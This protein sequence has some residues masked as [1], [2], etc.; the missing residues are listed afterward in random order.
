MKKWSFFRPFA[1]SHGKIDEEQPVENTL[2]QQLDFGWFNVFLLWFG[3]AAH[4]LDMY[5]FDVKLL[6]DL[7]IE[8]SYDFFAAT[9]CLVV[10]PAALMSL[11]S[12]RWYKTLLI[13]RDLPPDALAVEDT[14]WSKIIRIVCHILLIS[15][16]AR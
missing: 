6:Y 1:G 14:V 8:G 11:W 12:W 15:S 9:L 2:D 4:I 13:E 10:I 5:V 7:Y 16:A 3:V